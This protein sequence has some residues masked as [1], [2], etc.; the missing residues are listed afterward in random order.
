MSNDL[1]DDQSLESLTKG[2]S[3]EQLQFAEAAVRFARLALTDTHYV[4]AM[5]ESAQAAFK[6]L[7]VDPSDEKGATIAAL[8]ILT[9]HIRKG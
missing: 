3:P 6:M 8:L 7:E 5:A 1:G 4:S 2:L 9:A